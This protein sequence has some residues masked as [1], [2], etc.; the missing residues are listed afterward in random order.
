MDTT[1]QVNRVRDHIHVGLADW[2]LAFLGSFLVTLYIGGVGVLTRLC[3]NEARE[4]WPA[5]RNDGCLIVL[6]PFLSLLCGILWPVGLVLYGVYS[7]LAYVAGKACA[8]AGSC[9]GFNYTAYKAR[10]AARRVQKDEAR[11]QGTQRQGYTQPAPT[12]PP[13]Y[14]AQP[15]PS[16]LEAGFV[17]IHL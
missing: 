13:A 6:L 15:S 8:D 4:E 16:D 5:F 11:R 1:A 14:T 9:C 7:C 17:Y 10:R 2:P 3:Y 12:P